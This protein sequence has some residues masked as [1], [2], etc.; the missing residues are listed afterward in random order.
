[1]PSPPKKSPPP[2]PTPPPPPTPRNPTPPPPPT[3]GPLPTPGEHTQTALPPVVDPRVCVED[4]TLPTDPQWKS[5]S[6][7]RDA[8]T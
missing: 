4:V 3:P 8:Q 7:Q 5:D 6:S 2:L 1:M